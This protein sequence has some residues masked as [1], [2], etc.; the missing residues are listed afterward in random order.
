MRLNP[1]SKKEWGFYHS[2]GVADEGIKKFSR[3]FIWKKMR[4]V[5]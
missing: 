5:V 3:G 4:N 2:P 1:I